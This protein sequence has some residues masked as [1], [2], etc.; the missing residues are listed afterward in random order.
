M[1]TDEKL[2]QVAGKI[3]ALRL[4]APVLLFLELHQPVT[5]LLHT[6]VIFVEPLLRVFFGPE[7][8]S[9]L[10]ELLSSRSQVERFIKILEEC[11]AER[12]AAKNH[13]THSVHAR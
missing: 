12:D 1:D 3:A 13:S 5:P 10:A 8:L 6:A 9:T 4:E 2:H 11:A 7:L